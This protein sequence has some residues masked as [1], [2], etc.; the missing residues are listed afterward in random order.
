[1]RV[2]AMAA[3]KTHSAILTTGNHVMTCGKMKASIPSP[4]HPVLRDRDDEA[5]PVAHSVPYT[6]FGGLGY[7]QG[8]AQQGHV[9]TFRKIYQIK[10]QVAFYDSFA[11]AT[12][13]KVQAWLIGVHFDTLPR[14]TTTLDRGFMN[15]IPKEVMDLVVSKLWVK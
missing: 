4:V 15:N 2:L 14:Q 8:L 7:F 12:L 3:G 1:M 9:N 11:T 13:A 6:G 5:A 10:S